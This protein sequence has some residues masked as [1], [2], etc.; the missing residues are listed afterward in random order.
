MSVSDLRKGN[1]DTLGSIHSQG[2]DEI[3]PFRRFYAISLTIE[4]EIS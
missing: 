1:K 2:H 3:A 4:S